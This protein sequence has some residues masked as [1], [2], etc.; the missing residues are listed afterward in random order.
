MLDRE[1][2]YSPPADLLEI[3]NTSSPSH[4][5]RYLAIF[6]RYITRFLTFVV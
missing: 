3:E 4:G 5:M 6:R 1:K 2:L